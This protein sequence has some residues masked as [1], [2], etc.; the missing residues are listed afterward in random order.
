MSGTPP[1]PRL[2]SVVQSAL[3]A[4]RPAW[5]NEMCRRRYGD[6]FAVSMYPFGQIVYLTEPGLIKSILTSGGDL[7]PAGEANSVLDFV[8][9]AR[10]LLLLDGEC[11]TSRRRMLMPPFHGDNVARYSTLIDSVA[12]E[13]IAR[14]PEHTPLRIHHRLQWITLELMMRAVFGIADTGHLAELHRLVPE[15]LRI[16]PMIMLF[17]R[18]RR[19]LGARSPWGRFVRAQRGVDEILCSE[20]ER[21][22]AGVHGADRTDVLSLLLTAPSANAAS[23]SAA[24]LRDHL[25]TLLAVGHET[26]ATALAWVIERLTRHPDVLTRLRRELDAGDASYLEAVICETLRV[27]PVTMDI[28]RTVSRNTEIGGYRLDAGTMVAL[29]LQLL[30][31]SSAIYVDPGAFRPE[32]F[33]AAPPP[34]FHFLPFGGGAH[35]C[36]GA[37]FAMMEMKVVLRTFL[38]LVDASPA[39]TREE[40]MHAVGPM[41]VPSRGAEIVIRHRPGAREPAPAG[42]AS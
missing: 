4:A 16:H 28:A 18:L 10:S 30:H 8:V 5:F 20:I 21:R 27:R 19:D 13:E 12:S 40:T 38:R 14:W 33:L 22:R 35:R 26:T 24:E 36:L 31:S 7:F 15:L 11:H 9:G 1:G 25:V 34:P 23:L 17:P 6:L 37:T 3:W 32:R 41:L 39:R 42:Q 29:S 2:P